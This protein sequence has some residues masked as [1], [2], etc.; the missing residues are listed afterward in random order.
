MRLDRFTQR[1]QEAIVAAQGLAQTYNH[2]QIEPEHLLLVLLQQS[3]GVVPEILQQAGANPASVQ[4][5]LEADLARQL[6][7]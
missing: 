4:R 6:P 1:G 3:E 2:S 5:Q 7:D